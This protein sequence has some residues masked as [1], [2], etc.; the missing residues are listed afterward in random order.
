MIKDFAINIC[1]SHGGG[2]CEWM[3]EMPTLRVLLPGVYSI[4]SADYFQPAPPQKLHLMV[5]RPSSDPK[6]QRFAARF[7]AA[8][9]F[10]LL[11]ATGVPLRAGSY[12][13]NF[14]SGT[15][16]TQTIGGGDLSVLSA[17]AGPITTKV[18]VWAQGNKGLQLMGPLG[19]NSASWKMPD[20]DA[21]K[22]I[23]AFDAT[24]AAGTYRSAA[25]AVPGA[26]WS[27]NFGAVPTGNGSGEGGFVMPNGLVIA[28]DVFNNGGTDNPSIEVFSN[29]VSVGNFPSA[30]LTDSPV[31]DSG[32]FTLTNPVSGG[33]TAPILFDATV[34]TV[35]AAMRLVTG[36]EAVTVAAGASGSWAIDHGVAGAYSDPVSDASGIVPATSAVTVT[37]SVVGNAT[38]N[39]QWSVA[40]RAY[41]GRAV[42]VHWDYSGLDLN[43]GGVQVFTD[44]PTP[45]FIPALG[46]K[47]AFSARCESANTMDLFFDDVVLTTQQLQPVETGG[48]VISEFMAD[49]AGALSDEDTDSP[50]WIEIY[51]GQ[52]VTANLA[53]WRL[54]NTQGNNAMWTFPSISMAPY[55]Y[56][57]VY[58]SGKNRAVATGQLH[59][60][61]TLQ[62]ESGYLALVKADGVTIATQ[63]TYGAQYEDVS[64][65]EK[66]PL[67]TLGY[68]QPATPGAKVSY[69]AAQEAGGPAEAVVW[70]RE[71][72]I[73]TAGT[74]AVA[75]GAPVAAGSV[76]RYSVNNTEPGP[77]S[78][79][80][81][82]AS[83][84]AAFTVTATTTL[85]ARV[86]TPGLLP[87]PVSSRTFLLIDSSL[88]NYNGSG[89]VFSSHLPIIVM[90][91]F[92]VPVDSYNT[93]SNR[94][95]RLSYAV[96]LDK[97][98][99][100]GRASLTQAA[101]NYQGRGGTHV[102]GSSSAD[103]P[104][105]QYAWE[106]WDNANQD[107]DASILGMPAE[108]DWILYAPYD[109]KVLF[110]NFLIYT[111]M[112]QLTG[113]DGYA[114]RT[115]FCEVFFNQ[116]PGQP[117]S[118]SDYR[119]VY[120]LVEKIKIAKDRIDLQKVQIFD[121]MLL[122]KNFTCDTVDCIDDPVFQ[123]KAFAI[124]TPFTAIPHSSHSFFLQ[125]AQ[126]RQPSR[127]S[128]FH[129]IY[130]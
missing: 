74:T 55:S 42:V 64:Y 117:V 75:I 12:S 32:T 65:G 73:I 122:K 60:N 78:P 61:F 77:A 8:L 82:P 100:T 5:T 112:R 41:R 43:V 13:Q 52:N 20:L 108:S 129:R 124:L 58:A 126:L 40:P 6:S 95:Y 47:F 80:Y 44:L 86:F 27:L 10:L 68:L 33:V 104:Q 87:G 28:W 39:E 125:R 56:K 115:R 97:D 120:I 90:D 101:V 107:K 48:P 17:T 62:K 23:Q 94:P 81:N 93:A 3:S 30:T 7:I 18:A 2:R 121:P 67:R 118:Y 119:G 66:G 54:T 24:F 113:G 98:A 91:S 114:M 127:K 99:G 22:E 116:E 1:A 130:P 26:G 15:V 103:F 85:R 88:T 57:I 50:D 46:N 128:V 25:A 38:T 84:P 37:K 106:T 59:T 105:R 16:G 76:V 14:A 92:G 49:N 9:V 53:G 31:P 111:R 79:I 70:S 63:F 21:G 35:Q 29:G 34:A 51:N 71:G 11:L 69:S 36:W 83:P 96:V 45:G 123:I 4:P 109:D 102:R 89:Q 19:G 110:R 72:G